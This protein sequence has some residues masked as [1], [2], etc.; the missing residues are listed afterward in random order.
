MLSLGALQ[1]RNIDA[2]M[3][4]NERKED[5]DFSIISA[6]YFLSKD[7]EILKVDEDIDTICDVLYN[8]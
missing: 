1:S 7:I 3:V 5:G 2:M 4:F 8:L 6:P